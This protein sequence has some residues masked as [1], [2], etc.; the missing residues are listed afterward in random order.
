MFLCPPELTGYES[1]LHWPGGH[2][3]PGVNR[4]A[5]EGALSKEEIDSLV[6]EQKARLSQDWKRKAL[7]CPDGKTAGSGHEW[8]P[9]AWRVSLTGKHLSTIMCTRCFHEV[10]ISEAFQHRTKA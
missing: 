6:D 3:I 1:Q 2:Q 10:N 9:I 5:F 7:S 8:M 4:M